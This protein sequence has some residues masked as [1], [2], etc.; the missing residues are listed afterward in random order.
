MAN[1]TSQAGEK[2]QALI[3]GECIDT[4]AI[5]ALTDTQ[6]QAIEALDW[7]QIWALREAREQ[8]GVVRN[9]EMI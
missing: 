8:V 5:S 4:N 9:S 1:L 3:D 2:L 6:R 7:S